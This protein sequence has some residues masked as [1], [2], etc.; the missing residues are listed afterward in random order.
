V[1][2][3]EL[4][5]R[6]V[7]ITRP[8][9]QAGELAAAVEAHGGR[10]IL[11][12]V[13]EIE[14]RHPDAVAADANRLEAPDICIFVSAN[15]VRHGLQ[16]AADS[17]ICA[18]GPTTAAAIE[19]SGHPNVISAAAG[20][21]SE[22]LLAELESRDVSGQTIR[23][24]R[25]EG[26][27]EV[28]AD[29]LR[30]RGARVDYLEVYAR[31]IPDYSAKQID[32]LRSR[33]SDGDIHIVTVMSVESLQNLLKLLD[34]AALKTIGRLPL[35]TPSARVIKEAHNRLTEVQ[36]VL[37]HGPQA[38]DMIRAMIACCKPRDS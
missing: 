18:I 10:P 25:G 31:R 27:R 15:A 8:E 13:L 33:L 7:L 11:L 32:E 22:H 35:V 12:P 38:G 23:I 5:G 9:T 14:P 28:L 6:G 26:G 29:T 34:P 4:G 30:A 2:S 36:P 3:D 19:E 1:A 21:D 37:A 24:V 20:F 16:Y 17:V